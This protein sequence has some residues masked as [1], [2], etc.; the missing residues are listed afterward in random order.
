MKKLPG[1]LRPPKSSA[2][3]FDPFNNRLSRDIRNTLACAYVDALQQADKGIYQQT[4]ELWL[5]NKLERDPARYIRD[6]LKRYDHAFDQITENRI[7]DAKLQALIIWN[8]RLF[9]EVHELLERVWQQTTG[10]EFQALKGLIQAAGVY[11]HLEY[12]HRVAAEKLAA[13]SSDRIRKYRSCLKFI[14]NLDTLLGKLL[15]PDAEPP[16]LFS[17]EIDIRFFLC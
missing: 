9:F 5:A 14:A 4:A 16:L 2:A 10:D 17:K 12:K 1:S 6:R 3:A 7:R 15:C 11:V 13:K 8:H